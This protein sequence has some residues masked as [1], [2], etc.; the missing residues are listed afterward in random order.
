MSHIFCDC[1]TVGEGSHRKAIEDLLLFELQGQAAGA[2]SRAS[3]SPS[4]A[5]AGR[6][7]RTNKRRT[8]Q[9]QEPG[10]AGAAAAGGTSV[11]ASPASIRTHSNPKV[12]RPQPNTPEVCSKLC[13][14]TLFRNGRT[15]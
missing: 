15:E 4:A 14:A 8:P 9:Q 10:P 5:N 12:L 1:T 2:A 11:S 6:H 3:P 13:G 7:K